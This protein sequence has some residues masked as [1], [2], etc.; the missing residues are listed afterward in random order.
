MDTNWRY[1]IIIIGVIVLLLLCLICTCNRKKSNHTINYDD[2][3]TYNHEM[4][5]YP[6]KY[7]KY[8][9]V[10]D[11]KME[12]I[13]LI[14]GEPHY[15][16]WRYGGT[17]LSGNGIIYSLILLPY[18]NEENKFMIHFEDHIYLKPF[19]EK[20]NLY[21]EGMIHSL[22]QIVFLTSEYNINKDHYLE[23]E[24]YDVDEYDEDVYVIKASLWMKKGPNAYL[25]MDEK[26]K[27]YFEK[28]NIYD[29]V[30][31]FYLR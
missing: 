3:L 19:Y 28:E 27:L 30:A 6:K 31:L 9:T 12:F 14:D 25:H 11:V 1:L 29:N 21:H 10:E 26:N 24:K 13:K 16:T 5:L 17:E 15:L 18:E 4:D 23:I 20:Y 7:R 2:E 22:D 8:N